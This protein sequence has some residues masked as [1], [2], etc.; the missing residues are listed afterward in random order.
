MIQRLIVC[1]TVLVPDYDQAIGFYVGTLGFTLIEDTPRGPGKR[2]VLVSPSPE[3]KTRLLLAKATT[4]E[5]LANVGNQTA[6]RVFMFL[7]TDD[8]YRDYNAY[9]ARGVTFHESPREEEYATVVVFTDLY[10]NRWDL[11]QPK[12]SSEK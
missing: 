8:F 9:K 3:A 6:G 2:W 12:P 5:Q 11:L 7:Q 4:P 10:G 1:V